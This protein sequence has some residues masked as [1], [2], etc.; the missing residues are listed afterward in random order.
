MIASK[1]SV[2]VC[3]AAGP[4]FF[5]F[6]CLPGQNVCPCHVVS[7][8]VSNKTMWWLTRGDD[9]HELSVALLRKATNQRSQILFCGPLCSSQ[10]L[11]FNI[12]W[13]LE[14]PVSCVTGTTA[15]DSSFTPSTMVNLIKAFRIHF[16]VSPNPGVF[17]PF[18]A[19]NV[20]DLIMIHDG[21]CQLLVALG[22]RNERKLHQWCLQLRHASRCERAGAPR[23]PRAPR[24]EHRWR[25]AVGSSLCR[26]RGVWP[27]WASSMRMVW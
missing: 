27:T 4:D 25:E 22:C 2:E 26:C 5:D 23:A 7:S 12:V 1:K 16:G 24:C 10:T 18:Y 13:H 14:S 20:F 3:L 8:H 11:D 19:Y 6:C 15:R 21:C 17:I 9:R